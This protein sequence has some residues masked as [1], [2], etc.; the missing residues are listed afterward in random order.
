M[1]LHMM[2]A[3]DGHLLPLKVD[4]LNSVHDQYAIATY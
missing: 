2:P 4:F 1:S 3:Y